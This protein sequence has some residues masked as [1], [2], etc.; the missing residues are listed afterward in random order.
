MLMSLTYADLSF[1][2][3]DRYGSTYIL[4]HADIQFDQL[5]LLKMLSF[6]HC[7]CQKSSVHRYVGLFL[8]L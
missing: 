8:G 4:L 7:L 6:L 5:Y 3:S 1:V 2:Q